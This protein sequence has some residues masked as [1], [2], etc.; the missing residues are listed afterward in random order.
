MYG[1]CS[2]AVYLGFLICKKNSYFRGLLG[3]INEVF[4]KGMFAYSADT[5]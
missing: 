1:N 4:S 2:T 5:S 3:G